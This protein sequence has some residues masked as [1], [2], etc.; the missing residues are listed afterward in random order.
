MGGCGACGCGGSGGCGGGGAERGSGGDSSAERICPGPGGPAPALGGDGP[1]PPIDKPAP[2]VCEEPP[3]TPSALSG[4]EVSA[5][6]G[7]AGWTAAAD[8]GDADSREGDAAAAAGDG[9][10]G[11]TSKTRGWFF[12]GGPE[13]SGGAKP[14]RMVPGCGPGG[15]GAGERGGPAQAHRDGGQGA[16]ALRGL[17]RDYRTDTEAPTGCFVAAIR[18]GELVTG[19]QCRSWQVRADSIGHLVDS[20][21]CRYVRLSSRTTRVRRRAWRERRARRKRPLAHDRSLVGVSVVPVTPVTPPL[22]LIRTIADAIVVPVPL[23]ASPSPPAA[24]SFCKT[25]IELQPMRRS[26]SFVRRREAS[27][28]WIIPCEPAS[29]RLRRWV[30]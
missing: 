9:E 19:G 22:P 20:S 16:G 14:G 25:L 1:R 6:Y 18:S 23:A 29:A 8:P 26:E 30:Q 7:A 28:H 11:A 17:R 3:R 4:R 21:L 5:V 24:V 27:L 12:G 13:G 2:L 15:S 10:A